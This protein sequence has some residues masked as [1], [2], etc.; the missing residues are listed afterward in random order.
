[1]ATEDPQKKPEETYKQ[2]LADLAAATSPHRSRSFDYEK[3]AIDYS[4]NI[5]RTLTYLNG[6]AMVA[7]PTAVALF[8]FDAKLQKVQLLTSAG[9]FIAGLLLVCLAQM[10]AFFTMARRA[11]AEHLQGNSQSSIVSSIHYP[12]VTDPQ[13]AIAQANEN[14]ADVLK[15]V[16]NSD[17]HRLG[18]IISTWLS[19]VAFVAGCFFGG[20]AI[21]KA[22]IYQ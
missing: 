1:M 8:G 15:K 22:P 19:A 6:G 17:W 12:A 3:L 4:T 2:Y 13:K 14:H 7:L 5:F 10:F 18:G 9:M 16:G 11:E 20:M 21:L